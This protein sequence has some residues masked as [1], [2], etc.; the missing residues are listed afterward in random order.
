VFAYLRPD[1]PGCESLLAAMQAMDAETVCALPGLPAGWAERFDRIR[2]HA[3]AVDTDRLLPGADV[4]I[5]SGSGT[6]PTCLLAGVPVLV[7]P[8]FIEQYL[9]GLRLQEFGAGLTLFRPESPAACRA[10]LERL[11]HEPGFR[12]QARTFAERHAGHDRVRTGRQVF[13]ALEGLMRD[14]DRA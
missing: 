8:Q 1:V 11:I 5:T 7:A 4:A 2:F 6:I 12:R 10:R 3:G 9:A 13:E 14:S